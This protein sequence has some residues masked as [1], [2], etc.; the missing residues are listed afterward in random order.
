MK[1]NQLYVYSRHIRLRHNCVVFRLQHPDTMYANSH[2]RVCVGNGQNWPEVVLN[3][4]ISFQWTLKNYMC[5]YTQA[6]FFTITELC[7]NQE[8]FCRMYGRIPA[9]ERHFEPA[10]N[11][12]YLFPIALH[13]ILGILA[14]IVLAVKLDVDTLRSEGIQ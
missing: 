8:H 10:L 1:L 5:K 2:S 11:V 7:S 4:L 14:E 12:R 3:P 6:A 9:A 13:M